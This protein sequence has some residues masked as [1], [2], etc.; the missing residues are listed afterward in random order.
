MKNKK[1]PKTTRLQSMKTTKFAIFIAT[2]IITSIQKNQK[3]RIK[4][5][6]SLMPKRKIIFLLEGW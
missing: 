6:L 4:I 5:N 3:Y 2:A 1:A